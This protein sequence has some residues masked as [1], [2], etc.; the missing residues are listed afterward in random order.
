MEKLLVGSNFIRIKP[1]FDT[2]IPGYK[3][4]VRA[5]FTKKGSEFQG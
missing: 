3:K 4:L 1:D 5:G 2:V